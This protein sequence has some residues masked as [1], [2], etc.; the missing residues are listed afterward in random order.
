MKKFACLLFSVGLL[1]SLVACSQEHSY[2][3]SQAR[4]EIVSLHFVIVNHT[5]YTVICEVEP[6]DAEPLLDDLLALEYTD[7]WVISNPSFPYDAIGVMV[8]YQNGE[9]D[10]ITDT[11]GWSYCDEAAFDAVIDAYLGDYTIP[12]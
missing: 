10:L 12:A 4:S 3:L 8:T 2:E 11:T 5:E 7:L 9:Y 6:A 1:L